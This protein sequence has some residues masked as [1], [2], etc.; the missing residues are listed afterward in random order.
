MTPAVLTQLKAFV[1][2]VGR[3]WS[4]TKL[5]G[6]AADGPYHCYNCEYLKKSEYGERFYDESGRGRCTHIAVKADPEVLK[7]DK[8]LP[9]INVVSGCCE[10]VEPER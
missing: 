3:I 9:I 4:G 7:D 5:S 6:Y 2:R 10:F 1:G 8:G